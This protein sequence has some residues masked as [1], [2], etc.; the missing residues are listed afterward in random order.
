MKIH[1]CFLVPAPDRAGLIALWGR[2]KLAYL[3]LV[4]ISKCCPYI[5]GH[6]VSLR[7]S[8]MILP[9]T[10]LFPRSLL[11][12]LYDI[13]IEKFSP[14][15]H[16][17]VVADLLIATGYVICVVDWGLW[18]GNAGYVRFYLHQWYQALSFPL[19]WSECLCYALLFRIV[20]CNIVKLINLI[21]FCK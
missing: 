12:L 7:G 4:F 17:E 15:N 20:N 10:R 2:Y 5:L 19:H 3:L 8:Y 13:G 1:Y 18:A 9:Q 16:G 14:G 21:M 11:V 6:V